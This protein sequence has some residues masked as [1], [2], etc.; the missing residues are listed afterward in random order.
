M[1]LD[2]GETVI[3]ESDEYGTWADW[4]AVPRHTFS[5]VFGA[6]IAGGGDARDAFAHFRPGFDLERE[7]ERRASA[8][9]P[10]CFTTAHVY[11]DVWTCLDGLRA[12]GL[13]VGLAGNQSAYAGAMVRSLGLPVV[14]TSAEWGVAKPNAA[15]FETVAA[16]IGYAVH[17][18]LYVGDRLDN[19]IRP[20][21]SLGMPT[22]ALRRGPW[23]HVLDDPQVLDKCLFRLDSLVGLPELI[24]AHNAAA[25]QAPATGS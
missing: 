21:Q 24:A 10:E 8:G 4:L 6:V 14:G 9:H 7:R 19:D 15:F 12:Q 20:A 23:G 16:T 25:G 17:A 2:V 5:A 13:F 11:P 18:I 22:A 1:I 3:D